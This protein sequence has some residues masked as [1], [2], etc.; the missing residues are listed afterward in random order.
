[1]NKFNKI[2]KF[3]PLILIFLLISNCEAFKP[4]KVNTREV[5]INA[6]EAARKNVNE[7]R[8]VNL[9]KLLNRGGTNFEFS[10]SNPLWRASLNILDFIPLST[11]DYSGGII[12]TDWYKSGDTNDS[13]KITVRFLSNEIASSSLKII[14]HKKNCPP[15]SDCSVNEFNSK[16]NE[17]LL[18]SILKQAS[19]LDSKK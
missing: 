1:M 3:F 12:I 16:I 15:V 19:L 10:S 8:G 6:R 2:I 18:T 13:I 7:G 14:V 4:K 5:P 11:V 9:N 17:E